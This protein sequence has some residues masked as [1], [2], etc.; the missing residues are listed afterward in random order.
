M[1]NIKLLLLIS[2]VSFAFY[3]CNFIGNVSNYSK[4]SKELI[5]GIVKED[6]DKVQSLCVIKNDSICGVQ[7]DTFK[8][9]IP[10]FRK[11]LISNFGTQLS[12]TFITAEKT[13]GGSE[14]STSVSIQ[15]ENKQVFGVAEIV[16][17]DRVNKVLK[18]N[19]KNIKDPVPDMT[20]F[21]LFGLLAI[22]IPLFN[23]YTIVKIKRTKMKK[24]WWGYIV[25]IIFNFPTII[26][27]AI[28]GFSFYLYNFQVLLGMGFSLEGYL[29]SIWSFGIPLG[30]LFMLWWL[31]FRVS[32]SE[33]SALTEE[34]I[35][36]G[37]V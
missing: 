5:D 26:Y 4:T 30:S 3:G 14:N 27:A 8:R 9:R 21:W 11:V 2:F 12:Y 36:E 17:D 19:I 15:F 31:K 16:F 1:N 23:I 37:N 33:V 29:N 20:I 18:F 24:K 10:I 25:V 6:Y 35:N 22:S 7:I 32:N 34:V 28:G 13:L